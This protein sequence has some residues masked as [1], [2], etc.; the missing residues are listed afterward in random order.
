MLEFNPRWRYRLPP[1]GKYVNSSVPQ[2]AKKD[3]TALMTRLAYESKDVRLAF[4][5][6]KANFRTVTGEPFYGSS[7][8]S[9]AETDAQND[10]WAAASANPV[11]FIEA[12]YNAIHAIDI[13]YGAEIAIDGLNAVLEK[14]NLGWMIR[15]GKLLH[16]EGDIDVPAPPATLMSQANNQLKNAWEGAQK[17]LEQG[18][19]RKAV[20]EL[21]WVLESVAA[22][23]EGKTVGSTVVKGDYFVSIVAEL[24]KD[25]SSLNR[26]LVLLWL[27]GLHSHLSNP[28]GGGVRHGAA[29]ALPQMELHEAELYC[30]LIRSYA[31]YLLRELNRTQLK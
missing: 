26:K 15:D 16:R 11:L 31:V 21:L 9:F 12:F 29:P 13:P 25:Q 30:N 18:E 28:K 19:G 23:F 4:E 10:L 6:F 1:D 27:Q 20:Q 8:L 17:Y 5:N 24:K 22:A 2:A 14:H 7:S 3:F